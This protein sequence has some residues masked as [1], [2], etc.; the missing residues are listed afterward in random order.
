M[1][2]VLSLLI[3]S[4]EKYSKLDLEVKVIPTQKIKIIRVSKSDEL[5]TQNFPPQKCPPV[6]M[7]RVGNSDI[8]PPLG[9]YCKSFVQGVF[10]QPNFPYQKGKQVAAKQSWSKKFTLSGRSQIIFF[11]S[12]KMEAMTV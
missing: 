4:V 10:L 5:H 1:E 2:L 6:G 11:L 12:L 9:C 7:S 8:Q 3:I